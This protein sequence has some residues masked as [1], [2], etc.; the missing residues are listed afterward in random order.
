MVFRVSSVSRQSRSTA[1][2]YPVLPTAQGHAASE[3]SETQSTNNM[4]PTQSEARW[5]G[6][7]LWCGSHGF[8]QSV[9]PLAKALTHRNVEHSQLIE[10]SSEPGGH[11]A[12]ARNKIAGRASV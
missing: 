8:R 12:F 2:G 6:G 3:T 1:S 11:G 5:R 10:A 4:R 9:T 7:P